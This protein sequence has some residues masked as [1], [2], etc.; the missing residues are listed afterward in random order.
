MWI[1]RPWSRP[2]DSIMILLL[3]TA[4]VIT[5]MGAI[6]LLSHQ[7]GDS[8]HLPAFPGADKLAHMLVYGILALTFLWSFGEK[9][10][11]QPRRTALL[12]VLFC[13]C[14]GLGDEYHQSFIA[15]R[16]VSAFD[17]LADTAGASI[18][19]WVWWK[20]AVLRQKIVCYQTALAVRLAGC[21]LNEK[22]EC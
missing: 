2:L 14:Y 8:L 15:F 16:S 3:R 11:R 21:G 13:L 12:T 19:S 7:S 4:P 17:I 6:F 9:G 18:V 1:Q 5:V 22:N 20:S 10:G